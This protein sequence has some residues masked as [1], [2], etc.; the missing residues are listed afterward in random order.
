V[1]KVPPDSLFIEI[2]RRGGKEGMPLTEV[3][4]KVVEAKLGYG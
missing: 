2:A 4:R 1:G 3:V